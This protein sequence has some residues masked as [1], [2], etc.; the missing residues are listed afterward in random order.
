VTFT[1]LG[2][3]GPVCDP[4]GTTQ[5]VSGPPGSVNN[6]E[7]PQFEQIG[8]PESVTRDFTT[9]KYSPL[10]VIF[11][12]YFG[13]ICDPDY[14]LD[15]YSAGPPNTEDEDENRYSFPPIFNPDLPIPIPGPQIPGFGGMR[16]KYNP[17][18]EEYYDC[19]PVY[20]DLVRGG[21]IEISDPNCVGFD[22]YPFQ[23]RLIDRYKKRLVPEP[24]QGPEFNEFYCLGFW[25]DESFDP[26][27]AELTE[28]IDSITAGIGTN[29][30]NEGLT[31]SHTLYKSFII[32]MNPSNSSIANTNSSK[33]WNDWMRDH[34]VS[35]EPYQ[36]GQG[37]VY[38]WQLLYY[39]TTP[40]TYTV[41]YGND[42]SAHMKFSGA[43]GASIPVFDGGGNFKTAPATANITF[44]TAGWKRFEF[45]V[46]NAS[47]SS[48]WHKNP[49]GLGVVISGIGFDMRTYAQDNSSGPLYGKDAYAGEVWVQGRKTTELELEVAHRTL[50][51]GEGDGPIYKT[52]QLEGG[53]INVQLGSRYAGGGDTSA[54]QFDLADSKVFIHSATISGKPDGWL[55]FKSY[56]VELP[57]GKV[58]D[59]NATRAEL[60]AAGFGDWIQPALDNG[61]LVRGDLPSATKGGYDPPYYGTIRLNIFASQGTT[62][63][64]RYEY[65]PKS[66]PETFAVEHPAWSDW[67]NQYAVWV[68]NAEC[69]LPDDP[70]QVTY[71]VNFPTSSEYVFEVGSDNIT[72]IS[73]DGENIGP[74]GANSVFTDFKS[75]P[76]IFTHSVTSG[77]RQ[78]VV[79]CTNVDN[80]Q[81]DWRKNPGGWAI[82]IS[83]TGQVA[84]GNLDVNFDSQ[85]NLVATGSGTASVSLELDWDDNP[86]TFGQALG[87]LTYGSTSWT[88]TAGK[89]KGRTTKTLTINGAGTTNVTIQGG[90]GYGGFVLNNSKE[91]CFRDLDNT[92][93][94]AK[95]KITSVTNETSTTTGIP[96]SFQLWNR[97]E[98]D[99]VDT[100]IGEFVIREEGNDGRWNAVGDSVTQDFTMTGG[101]GSGLVLNM[102]LVA[103]ADGSDIDTNVRVNS[104]KTAGTG[105]SPGE[106]L[107]ISPGNPST[108]WNRG[109]GLVRINTVTNNLNN[110]VATSTGEIFHTRQGVG[111]ELYPEGSL[112]SA[113]DPI[114]GNNVLAFETV[115]TIVAHRPTGY[116]STGCNTYTD[117]TSTNVRREVSV[118]D[119]NN[120]E[121]RHLGGNAGGSCG[122]FRIR[123]IVDG[124]DIINEYRSNWEVADASLKATI[125]PQSYIEVV[126]SEGNAANAN[127]DTQT[128][129]EIVSAT[130][131]QRVQLIT[132][133][134]EPRP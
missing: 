13:P 64:Q 68:N 117:S 9:G 38:T 37:A 111:I 71:Y 18:T 2:Q 32:G 58:A 91:L 131:A 126:M 8:I 31:N 90:T 54:N 93:C 97:D 61:D 128:K 41:E 95:F 62:T 29:E 12:G 19:E 46:T 83:N 17:E 27:I 3:F 98:G 85:G 75:S 67:M 104:I 123:V 33:G 102:T 112:I 110:P 88:Q 132:C 39:V 115:S 14:F 122:S 130:N 65:E 120:A 34:A 79:T 21:E 11:P 24:Y 124:V 26:N 119:V 28:V 36:V 60:V 69:V 70:Q 47:G 96:T 77:A 78:M 5:T 106:V 105:Y 125:D 127:E 80:G 107:N 134:F 20:V 53:L 7:R 113:T 44:T 4:A 109:G 42:D 22:C 129:F 84:A 133:R 94:N 72:T 118:A 23:D 6:P 73:I 30:S 45:Q 87:T 100:N 82:R 63:A 59:G 89:T 43:E 101:N 40:G 49:V 57:T 76:T 86:N 10:T 1:P 121:I 103:N 114:K 16:C 48:A 92:D 52:I 55:G 108:D 50:F 116:A 35:P 56:I 15:P 74:N 51:F 99:W 81:G 66:R 25:P